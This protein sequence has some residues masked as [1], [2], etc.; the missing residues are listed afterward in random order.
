MKSSPTQSNLE[1]L[2]LKNTL[3]TTIKQDTLNCAKGAGLSL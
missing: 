2:A 3:N 1:W